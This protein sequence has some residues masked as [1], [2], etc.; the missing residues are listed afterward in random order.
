MPILKYLR[1]TLISLYSFFLSLLSAL[2]HAN[3]FFITLASVAWVNLVS[4]RL[5]ITP[6]KNLAKATLFWKSSNFAKMRAFYC[7]MTKAC[8]SRLSR[9]NCIA[10]YVLSRLI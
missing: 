3:A 2:K 5:K 6:W 1:V 4:C 9:R 10:S 7:S 8:K